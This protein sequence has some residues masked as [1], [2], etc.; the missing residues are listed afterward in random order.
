MGT[1][2]H[3]GF[4]STEVEEMVAHFQT[5]GTAGVHALQGTTETLHDE[6]VAA[7]APCGIVRPQCHVRFPVGTCEIFQTSKVTFPTEMR[8]E[9]PQGY[10]R[11]PVGI[12]QR[13]IKVYKKIHISQFLHILHPSHLLSSPRNLLSTR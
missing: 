10:L 3:S 11:I 8:K 7:Y 2:Y 1:R 13:V 4:L 9:F 6:V 5:I 12:V